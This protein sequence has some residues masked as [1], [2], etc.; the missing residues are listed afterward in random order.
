MLAL[1]SFLI[2]G[3]VIKMI[4][5]TGVTMPFVSYGGSSMISCLL[6]VGMLQAVAIRNGNLAEKGG[7][8]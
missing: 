5:L 8:A 3:G 4:P 1:Q 2:I 7:I 6:I